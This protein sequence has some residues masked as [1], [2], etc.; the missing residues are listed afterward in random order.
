MQEETVTKVTTKVALA[1][2]T[3]PARTR[4][5]GK[6]KAVEGCQKA[7]RVKVL[8]R[9][10]LSPATSVKSGRDGRYSVRLAPKLVA[11][12]ARMSGSR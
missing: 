12:E 7:R 6:V 4:L 1:I 5:A 11:N 10:G 9:G 3:T 8:E 2:K